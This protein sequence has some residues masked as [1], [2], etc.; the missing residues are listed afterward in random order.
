MPGPDSDPGSAGVIDV[1][2]TGP[3]KGMG[4]NYLLLPPGYKGNVP[5]GYTVVRSPTFNL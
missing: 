1:G 4:G 5:G 2:I 3:D